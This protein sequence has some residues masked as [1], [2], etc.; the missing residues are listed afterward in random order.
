MSRKVFL[1]TAVLMALAVIAVIFLP[2][3]LWPNCATIRNAS[4]QEVRDIR[5]V[6]HDLRGNA[7]LTKEVTQ[8]GP[9]ESALLRH[10]RNDLRA[11]MQFVLA[12]DERRFEVSYIDLWRGEGYVF[13]ILPDGSVRTGYDHSQ[14]K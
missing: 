4:G 2:R 5:L 12:G 11:E 13:E 7:A 9:G 3:F 1:P 10:N 14:P 6:L 8:L